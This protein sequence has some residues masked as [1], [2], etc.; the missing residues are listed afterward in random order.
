M[1][2][3]RLSFVRSSI[4]PTREFATEKI[5]IDKTESAISESPLLNS[6]KQTSRQAREIEIMNDIPPRVG[7]PHFAVCH[8]GPPS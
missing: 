7:V 8:A 3:F 2:L 4:S 6:I 1:F 5:R